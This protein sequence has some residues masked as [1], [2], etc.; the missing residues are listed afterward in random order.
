MKFNAEDYYAQFPGFPSPVVLSGTV[1]YDFNRSCSFVL[2]YDKMIRCGDDFLEVIPLRSITRVYYKSATQWDNSVYL[3][4]NVGD[5]T[6]K[7]HIGN[8]PEW[9]KKIGQEISK[10]LK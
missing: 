5:S 3:G 8:N 4:V 10:L 9:V 6:Y 1:L 2:T 7:F